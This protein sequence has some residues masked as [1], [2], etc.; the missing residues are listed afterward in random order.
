MLLIENN[1]RQIDFRRNFGETKFAEWE[2]L[3]ELVEN[4][5]LSEA[6]DRLHWILEKSGKF[7]TSSLY[8][9]IMNTGVRDVHMLL[10][11][12]AKIPLKIKIFRWQIDRDRIQSAV[13]LHFVDR[14]SK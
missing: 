2:E 8:K 6:Q 5:V 14:E 9:H 12:K 11:W 10:I 7:T 1:V 4:V 13:Q 3:T